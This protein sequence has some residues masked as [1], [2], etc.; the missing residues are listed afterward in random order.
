MEIEELGCI[1]AADDFEARCAAARAVGFEVRVTRYDGY[2]R[3]ETHLVR[4][5]G[6]WAYAR[7]GKLG[8]FDG[9]IFVAVKPGR[10]RELARVSGGAPSSIA[11]GMAAVERKGGV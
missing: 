3:R 4:D 1:N 7:S 8:E 10:V 6:V 2:G 11:D 9:C 5:G